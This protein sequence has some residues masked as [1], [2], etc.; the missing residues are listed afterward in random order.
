M[1]E[2]SIYALIPPVA[3]AKP[4]EPMYHSKFPKDVAPTA[5][6]FGLHGTG[7]PGVK[8]VGGLVREPEGAH[9]YKK[10]HATFGT[11]N[12]RPSPNDILR[13]TKPTLP[14][15]ARR[16]RLAAPCGTRDVTSLASP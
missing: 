10:A 15:R 11:L 14:D 8:N 6:T 12:N 13:A 4:R 16:A 1:Q 2:E 9:P 3:S 7:G 5:S